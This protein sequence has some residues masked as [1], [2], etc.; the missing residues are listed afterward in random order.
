MYTA[1]EHTDKKIVGVSGIVTLFLKDF[2]IL[3]FKI[4]GQ[5]DALNVAAS[6]EAL[7]SLGKENICFHFQNFYFYQININGHGFYYSFEGC[8]VL[9][10][11]QIQFK[12]I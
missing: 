4:Q 8:L 12:C 11:D 3:K 2:T 7:S 5:E 6:I 10:S 9:I 1:V